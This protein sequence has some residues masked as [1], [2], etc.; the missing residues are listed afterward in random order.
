M[1]EIVYDVD[2]IQVD[3]KGACGVG[4]AGVYVQQSYW[5]AVVCDRGKGGC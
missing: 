4:V 2:A 3:W 1:Y 5:C